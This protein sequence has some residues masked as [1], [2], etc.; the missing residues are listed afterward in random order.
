MKKL[1]LFS[2]LF[3]TGITVQ[4]Q[5]FTNL[6]TPTGTGYSIDYN[7][8]Y[9]TGY[10]IIS[11]NASGDEILAFRHF[12]NGPS[13]GSVIMAFNSNYLGIGTID[14]Q[15]KLHV[16]G[17]SYFSGKIGI[18]TSTPST[19][20]DIRNND[21][22]STKIYNTSNGSWL[23]LGISNCNGCFSNLSTD[24]DVVLRAYANGDD[25]VIT[26]QSDGEIIFGNGY[27][28]SEA[29]RMVL[30]TNGDFGIGTTSPQERL[31]VNGNILW[32]TNSTAKLTGDQGGS[33]KLGGASS[34][35]TPYLDFNNASS[36]SYDARLVLTGDNKLALQGASLGIG[37]N[38]PDEKLTV[39]GKIH[40]EEVRIDLSVPADYVFQSYYTGASDLKSD[41]AMPTLEEVEAFAKKNHH[42]PNIP[43]AASIQEN[44]LSV[45]EMTNLLL[46][47]IVELTLYTIEQ[48]K[49]INRL[50]KELRT[51][52]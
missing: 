21:N 15:Q 31:H 52:R 1:V 10:E 45:G 34:S 24:G 9:N 3:A 46:E 14:P 49:R 13:R 33:I 36:S 28:G 4:A 8:S 50:E 48:E 12:N 7:T 22:P 23:D 41:Y 5:Q 39:K 20:L 6:F 26:N 29:K 47:K 40:A 19:L 2:L 37:T 11:E 27:S 43:S 25:L 17:N 42:L 32:G 35:A 30:N 18:G 51:Q 38:N 44:G 16:N